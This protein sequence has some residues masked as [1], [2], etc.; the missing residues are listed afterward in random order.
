MLPKA[1][2]SRGP[3]HSYRQYIFLKEALRDL[4]KQLSSL[5]AHLVILV[6]NAVDI[7]ERINNEYQV[8]KI[9]SYQETWNLWTYNRD[10]AVKLWATNNKVEWIE[11]PKNGVI[12]NLD[13]RNGW[14]RRWYSAMSTPLTKVPSRIKSFKIEG[15]I[16]PDALNLNFSTYQPLSSQSATR[17]E[18]V[19]TLNSF[20]NYRGH[21]YTFE[22]SSP[23]TAEE[24]CSRISPY[25]A[26]GQISVREAFQITENRT[27]EVRGIDTKFSKSLKSFSSRLRWHCHFM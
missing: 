18:A 5:G 23:V 4:D 1:V 16:I 26:F 14:S 22:M 24:S 17:S 2:Q 21:N 12:R 10:K 7:F 20:L 25:L 8:N 11:K 9:F 15:D 3:D 19:N 13:Y 6:G 27:K